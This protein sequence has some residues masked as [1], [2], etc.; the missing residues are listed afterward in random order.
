MGVVATKDS[1]TYEPRIQCG[2]EVIAHAG[3]KGNRVDPAEDRPEE[4]LCLLIL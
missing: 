4:P 2:G 1:L 3:N